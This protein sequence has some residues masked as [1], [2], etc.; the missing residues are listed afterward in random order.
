ML[1]TYKC[2]EKYNKIIDFTRHELDLEDLNHEL[3]I[4][5]DTRH[6]E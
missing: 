5:V 4:S 1:R 2:Q 6:D 3:T